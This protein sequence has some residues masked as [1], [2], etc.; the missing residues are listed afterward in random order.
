MHKSLKRYTKKTKEIKI[1]KDVSEE[2]SNLKQLIKEKTNDINKDVAIEE[3]IKKDNGYDSM[4]DEI[5]KDKMY[6][7]T[8][9]AKTNIKKRKLIALSLTETSLLQ[10]VPITTNYILPPQ[11]RLLSKLYKALRA[12]Q[13]FNSAK[14]L[15]IIFIKSKKCIEELV[16]RRIEESHFRQLKHIA[17]DV[18]HFEPVEIQHLNR[19]VSSFIIRCEIVDFDLML[20]NY[21]K[22]EYNEFMKGRKEIEGRIDPEFVLKEIPEEDLFED[23]KIKED[24]IKQ[25]KIKQDKIKQ[26]KMKEDKFNVLPIK[27]EGSKNRLES[28]LERIKEKE[29]KRRELFISSGVKEDFRSQIEMV[30]TTE[31]KSTI[32][33]TRIIE[34]LNLFNGEPL[35]EK[36]CCENPKFKIKIINNEKYLII[37]KEEKAKQI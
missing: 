27:K 17:K 29:A 9:D 13:R 16:H 2:M 35:I 6:D 19:M 37:N 23:D 22:K 20:V 21:Y 24:K 12:I 31:N 15:N 3:E 30:F 28:I 10:S 1:N 11:L 5:G 36:L 32:K 4:E 7:N 18:F 34:L 8:E 25:D 33:M 14:L 26:D